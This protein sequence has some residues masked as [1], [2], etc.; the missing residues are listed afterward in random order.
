MAQVGFAGQQLM[1][2]HENR[3]PSCLPVSTPVSAVCVCPLC[4]GS[5]LW[6]N[7]LN[8]HGRCVPRDCLGHWHGLQAIRSCPPARTKPFH[9]SQSLCPC[10]LSVPVNLPQGAASRSGPI[11]H[12]QCEASVLSSVVAVGRAALQLVFS[13][14]QD[15]Q[16]AHR[17]QQGGRNVRVLIAVRGLRAV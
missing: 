15:I 9:A 7:P 6:V 3:A 12:P 11:R 2:C 10:P 13:N 1:F 5:S 14:G 17:C 4:T 16:F 8:C